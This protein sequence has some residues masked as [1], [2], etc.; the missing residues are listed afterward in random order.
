M[1]CVWEVAGRG[2]LVDLVEGEWD[3]SGSGRGAKIAKSQPRNIRNSQRTCDTMCVGNPRRRSISGEYQ[4]PVWRL[5][6]VSGNG[7]VGRFVACWS[8]FVIASFSVLR[9]SEN[10]R[11]FD[12][13][14]HALTL[15]L[16]L[17]KRD[18]IPNSFQILHACCLP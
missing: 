14:E 8:V 16:I 3:R 2:C 4:E 11:S 10:R 7:F 13:P 15:Q 6:G 17:V 1:V 5:G 18:Q 12:S 9:P